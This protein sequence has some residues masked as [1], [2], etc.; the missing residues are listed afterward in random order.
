MRS[1]PWRI[2]DSWFAPPPDPHRVGW[3]RSGTFAHRGLHGEGRVE[4][5]P[6]AFAAAIA[7]GFG[8]ECDVRRSRDGR[9]VVF[10]D[11]TLDRLTGQDGVLAELDIAAITGTVL[12]NGPDRIPTL[13]DLLRQVA[14][15]VPLL[16][17]IKADP[18]RGVAGLCHAVRRDLEGYRGQQAVMSFDLR[19]PAWFRRL[20]PQIVRGLVVT[21]RDA[22]TLSA[23]V[24][25]HRMVWQARPDFLAYDIRDL[26]SEFARQQRAR[27]L[28][29]LTWTVNSPALRQRAAIEADSPI[30][31]GEGL[32]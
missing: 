5:S 25:R 23:D 26:P 3:L 14:G 27:G 19:V 6:A 7:A 16:I 18:A 30:A 4:N 10:H 32:A 31:E 13:R 22:R 29:L 21:E 28:P 11:A 9:A 1:L 24:R 20:A 15:A 17:E 2:A 12:G 8:I